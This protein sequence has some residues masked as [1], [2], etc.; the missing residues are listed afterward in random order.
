MVRWVF[1]E[2]NPHTISLIACL[3]EHI[4]QPS[5]PNLETERVFELQ[6]FMSKAHSAD[7]FVA[8]VQPAQLWNQ[9]LDASVGKIAKSCLT[10]GHS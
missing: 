9:K 5:Y 4:C 7:Q 8:A 2:K 6:S 3:N 1:L 10:K